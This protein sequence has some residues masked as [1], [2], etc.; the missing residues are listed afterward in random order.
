MSEGP[1]KKHILTTENTPV[2]AESEQISAIKTALLNL[3]A[4]RGWVVQ[5]VNPNFETSDNANFEIVTNHSPLSKHVLSVLRDACLKSQQ[6]SERGCHLMYLLD[7]IQDPELQ[8]WTKSY[9]SVT[10]LALT[11][12]LECLMINSDIIEITNQRYMPLD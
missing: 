3:E 10:K 7:R 9:R 4:T 2:T 5:L 11:R 12:A 8:R 1:R 6:N